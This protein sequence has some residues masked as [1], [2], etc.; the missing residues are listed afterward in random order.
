MFGRLG[1]EPAYLA[2][3]TANRLS[4]GPTVPT[5]NTIQNNLCSLNVLTFALSLLARKVSCILWWIYFC[6]CCIKWLGLS[7]CDEAVWIDWDSGSGT[8]LYID[9][10]YFNLHSFH[11]MEA[12]L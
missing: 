10:I 11:S 5:F 1:I 3:V 9:Y 4:D 6:C 8:L 7:K 12:N 2:V